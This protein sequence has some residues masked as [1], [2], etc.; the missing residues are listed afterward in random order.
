MP[1]Q[2]PEFTQAM[3]LL[4]N[5]EQIKSAIFQDFAVIGNDTPISPGARYFSQDLPQT[6]FDPD[7][8]KHLIKKAGLAGGTI[9]IVASSAATGS[10]EMAVLLQQ[11]VAQAGIKVDVKVKP[12]DGY[13]SNHWMKHPLSFGNINPRPNADI[14]FSQ[15]FASTAAWNESHWKNKQFDQLLL[16]ARKETDDHKRQQMYEEMQTLVH[17]HCGLGIPVFISNIDGIDSRIKGYGTNPLGGFM[18][19]MFAENV[20]LDA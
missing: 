2:R 7:Q 3:K 13:W 20:W 6:V 11:S 14:I 12:A 5:R 16:N 1:G 10:V 18:G 4:L 15:F 17:D 8:A 19:Y 9:P